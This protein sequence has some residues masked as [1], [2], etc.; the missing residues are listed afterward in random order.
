MKKIFVRIAMLAAAGCITS[1]VSAC[2]HSALAPEPWLTTAPIDGSVGPGGGPTMYAK[3]PYFEDTTDGFHAIQIFDQDRNNIISVPEAADSGNRYGAVW[4]NRS[5]T[6]IAWQTRNAGLSPLLYT[7]FDTDSPDLGHGLSWWKATHPDWI[8]YEC[9]RTT[10][11]Y[12]SGLPEVPLDFANPA[13]AAYQSATLGSYAIANQYSGLAADI[14][15]MTNNTGNPQRGR[16][17]CGVWK[18]NHTKWV[19]RFSG[20]STDPLWDAAL[21]SWAKTLSSALHHSFAT[22]L[23][24]AVNTSPVS[25][26]GPVNGA[27]GDPNVRSLFD[28]VDIVLDEAGFSIW[29][30]YVGDTGFN[31][32]V[33]WA[34]YV[35][36]QSKAFILADD[37]NLQK[38]VPTTHEVDY[39]LATY[40]MGKEQASA[41]YIGKN[42]MYGAQNYYHQYTASIGKACAPM[43]G[44]PNDQ[45]FKGE[46]VYLRVYSGGLSIVNVDQHKQFQVKLPKPQYTN[47]EG[48]TV[49]SPVTIGPNSGLV[50]L[51]PGGCS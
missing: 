31:N 34:E 33:H 12:V 49:R 15:D 20:Q 44:G 18:N 21:I 4:G 47:I 2:G 7:P 36:S 9:D 37:W 6:A 45:K 42:D 22:P 27:G 11:A 28:N 14:V 41:L 43:Y 3:S 23:A 24:L 38:S 30:N 39:S 8:L 35:Q 13:V 5:A 26:A 40:L 46:R 32:V 19:Q 50:L 10:V 51:S 17:G 29:G 1:A 48:G 25:Y 16:G